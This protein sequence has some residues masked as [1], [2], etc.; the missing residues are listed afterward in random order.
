M[1]LGTDS[2][3]DHHEWASKKSNMAA[4]PSKTNTPMPPAAH[5]TKGFLFLILASNVAGCLAVRCLAG[6]KGGVSPLATASAVSG[7]TAAQ[8]ALSSLTFC[9]ERGRGGGDLAF[10]LAV[11][12]G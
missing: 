5:S 7:P 3:Q 4:R 11:L 9:R 6:T 2:T 10:V 8:V 12:V 1:M